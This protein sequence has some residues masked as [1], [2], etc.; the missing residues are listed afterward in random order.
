MP[1]QSAAYTFE[2]LS[3]PSPTS[4]P[5]TPTTD[6][7]PY[8][9]LITS[10]P[11]PSHIPTRYATHRTTRALQQRTTLL[12]PSFPGPLID[13]IL[14]RLVLTPSTCAPDPRHCLVLW[15]R[16]PP[17]IRAL[18]SH[19][20]TTLAAVLPALWAMPAANLHCTAL[21]VAH[22]RSAAD[23]AALVAGLR[24]NGAAARAVDLLAERERRGESRCVLGRPVVTY[25]AAAVALSFLPDEGAGAG[26]AEQG[27]VEQAVGFVR[28]AVPRG[29][30]GAAGVGEDK[31]E[32]EEE[33][34]G[35]YTYHHLRRDLWDICS[36]TSSRNTVG[37]AGAGVPIASR[38][39]VPSAHLTLM[40]FISAADVTVG[41][42]EDGAIDMSKMEAFV[43]A[44]EQLNAWLEKEVWG[45][46]RG[47]WTVG[48][49]M[50]LDLRAGTVW[51]GGGE[52]VMVGRGFDG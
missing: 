36:E 26:G 49:E 22:S 17:H 25:D 28:G 34:E 14:R 50:G 30:L 40:R 18:A 24:V 6:P 43:G 19:I 12:S 47:G 2:D 52:S 31:E 20:Q 45:T 8:T 48:E 3:G 16:P 15:A 32:V 37:S 35:C 38:Y 5:S 29:V 41:G 21:E 10:S 39:T 46:A 51:Y 27:L 44:I 9:P 7:N 4:T 1:E 13:P 11:S 33:R 23:V 42:G